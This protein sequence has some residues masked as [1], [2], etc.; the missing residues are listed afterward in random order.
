MTGILSIGEL[1]SANAALSRKVL[2]LE[3]EL[4][5]IRSSTLS[6]PHSCPEEEIVLR[7]EL[8]ST[9][10]KYEEKL[11]ECHKEIWR[12]RHSDINSLSYN[13]SLV[14]E[15]LDNAAEVLDNMHDPNRVIRALDKIGR[16]RQELNRL[17]LIA[18]FA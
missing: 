8:G 11:A 7:K 13:I 16:A 5:A 1:I 10:A 4:S 15:T 2:D 14:V 3:S 17:G 12:L 9:H 18:A 6:T